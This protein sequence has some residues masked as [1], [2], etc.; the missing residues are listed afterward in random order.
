MNTLPQVTE[1]MQTILNDVAERAART[2]GLI[3]RPTR[4]KLTG[5]QFVQTLVFGFLADPHAS[6]E[7]LARIAALDVESAPTRSTSV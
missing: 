3:R 5:A 6:R 7:A 4:V 1:A 2:N